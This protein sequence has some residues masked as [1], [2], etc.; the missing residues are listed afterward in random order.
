[1]FALTRQKED[2]AARKYPNLNLK[3]VK[4]V[5][6]DCLKAKEIDEA[7]LRECSAVIHSVGAITDAFDYKQFLN[8]QQMAEKVSG[9]GQDVLKGDGLKAIGIV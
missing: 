2:D 5:Q 3:N 4:F 8:P 6:G 7:I 9:F 1:M